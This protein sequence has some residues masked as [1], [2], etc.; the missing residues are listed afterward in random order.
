M[1]V[2]AESLPGND[3]ADVQVFVGYCGHYE[4]GWPIPSAYKISSGLSF[5][6]FRILHR[7]ISIESPEY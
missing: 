5:G 4:R 3:L 6:S 7:F 1:T 2:Q